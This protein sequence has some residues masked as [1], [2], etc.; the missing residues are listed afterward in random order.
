MGCYRVLFRVP[1]LCLRGGGGTLGNCEDSVWE[2]WGALG[3]IRGV[4]TPPPKNPMRM[5]WNYGSTAEVFL[6]CRG[7]VLKARS[8]QKLMIECDLGKS[9]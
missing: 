7:G 9:V 1:K 4:N 6:S 5:E 2:D 8:S 3:K